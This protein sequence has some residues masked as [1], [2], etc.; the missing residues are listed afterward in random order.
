MDCDI[1]TTDVD[2][3]RMKYDQKWHSIYRYQA[4]YAPFVY[5]LL[6]TSVRIG[7]VFRAFIDKT[8]G[9]L[10]VNQFSWAQ[11]AVFWGGKVRSC[12]CLHEDLQLMMGHQAFFAATRLALPFALLPGV[13]PMKVIG[14]FMVS[15]AVFSFTFGLISQV[16]LFPLLH[17][18]AAAEPRLAGLPRGRLRQ[19]AQGG[20]RLG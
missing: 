1:E 6:G 8:R 15:D 11:C 3:R 10:T 20:P 19:L 7:D 17:P 14:A 5:V 16:R 9:P 12:P 13:S 2:F 18:R 4:V